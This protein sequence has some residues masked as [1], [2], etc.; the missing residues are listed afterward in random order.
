MKHLA[1]LLLAA[2]LGGCASIVGDPIQ[3]IPISSNPAGAS[4]LIKDERGSMVF[5]GIT[6]TTVTLA[7]SDGTYWGG[8]TYLVTI[9]KPGYSSQTIPIEA[10]ANGWYIGGNI[11]FGGII[12][13]FIIDPLNGNMYNLS[14]EALNAE[15]AN[16]SA[17]NNTATDGSIRI[18]LLEQVPLHLRGK[19][20]EIK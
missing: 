3:H 9:S 1:T 6:P 20:Q 2:M 14:P 8:K 12:G 11:I 10:N 13:W 4:I 5:E 18:V 15:L 16:G 17:H 7:K 19:M